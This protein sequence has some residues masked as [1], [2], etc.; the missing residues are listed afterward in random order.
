MNFYK[1]EQCFVLYDVQ[2]TLDH[3]AILDNLCS[4]QNVMLLFKK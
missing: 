1:I 2:W 3:F 4:G